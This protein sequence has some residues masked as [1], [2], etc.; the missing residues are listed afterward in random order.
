[1]AGELLGQALPALAAAGGAAVVQAAGTDVWTAFR[2]R[3]ARLFGRGDT[4]RESAELER[5]DRT[6]DA[7][8]PGGPGE[9]A[10]RDRMVQEGVWQARFETLL[11]DLDDTD[12]E[13]VAGELQALIVLAASVPGG[14][15]AAGTG[16][17]TARDGGTATTGIHQTGGSSGGGGPVIAVNTGEAEAT[18][19]GSSATSGIVKS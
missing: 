4:A 15:V 6:H 2:A 13:R 18:G 8:A 12:R 1:M 17:A 3:V 19:T 7:L 10:V 11:E 9:G 16:K 14:V 5:L